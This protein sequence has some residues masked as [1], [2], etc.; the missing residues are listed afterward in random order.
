ML[1]SFSHPPYRGRPFHPIFP[2]VRKDT[3]L[4]LSNPDPTDQ[5]S[6]KDQLL[7]FPLII[8]GFLLIYEYQCRI[9]YIF[10]AKILPEMLSHTCSGPA[11]LNKNLHPCG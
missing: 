4:T 1:L 8:T 5:E 10:K 2:E 7:T 3:S 9:A 6:G 11:D